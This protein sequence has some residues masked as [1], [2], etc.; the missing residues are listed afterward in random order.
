MN[1]VNGSLLVAAIFFALYGL[2]CS[3]ECGVALSFLAGHQKRTRK[4]FTPLW[5]VT[6][7]FL[8]FGFTSVA[9]LFNNAL[10]VLS[11]ALLSTLVIGLLALL[12]RACIALVLFYWR[13]DDVPKW[14]AWLFALTCFA[15]P[16]SFT[17]AGVYLLTGQM[18]WQTLVGVM[19]MASALLGIVAIGSLALGRSSDP[20]KLIS[21]EVL[22]A[23]WL[24]F[25]G[26]LLPLSVVYS[27]AHLQHWPIAAIDLLSILGLLLAYV[28][29]SGKTNFKL[30]YYAGFVGLVTPLL[31]AWAN[32]PYL[33][34]GK[35]KLDDAFG[36][37]SYAGAFLLGSAIIF[38]LVALGLWLFI[39]LVR[40]PN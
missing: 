29:T 9:M 21:D 40:S 8:V 37:S 27:G 24:L 25:L 1:L 7:V 4:Y 13:P 30:K 33:V 6:N 17:A 22:L 10:P 11:H 28:V 36:A 14:G 19:L 16:L 31:L 3:V 15:I 12:L 2:A 39:K 23:A 20:K 38:P 5:E 18:F 34:N 35:I 26:S 32:R